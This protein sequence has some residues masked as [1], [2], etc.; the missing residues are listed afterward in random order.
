MFNEKRYWRIPWSARNRKYV[1][2]DGVLFST[3]TDH[4]KRT[5]GR[6]ESTIVLF[7]GELGG[8]SKT[9]GCGYSITVAISQS[10][11]RSLQALTE[12]GMDGEK[13]QNTLKTMCT[14]CTFCNYPQRI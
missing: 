6:P 5:M 2:S 10:R 4:H 3:L 14:L 13:T 11:S 12:K 7:P 9:P 1:S 8:I